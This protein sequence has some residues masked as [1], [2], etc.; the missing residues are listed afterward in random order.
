MNKNKKRTRKG[1]LGRTPCVRHSD[2]RK[3]QKCGKNL[4]GQEK[5]CWIESEKRCAQNKANSDETNNVKGECRTLSNLQ[6]ETNNFGRG[7]HLE[8]NMFCNLAEQNVNSSLM[9]VQE[10]ERALQECLSKGNDCSDDER[11]EL[12]RNL[13]R[14]KRDSQSAGSRNKQR[15]SKKTRNSKRRYNKYLKTRVKKTKKLIKGMRKRK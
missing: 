15:R 6:S 9:S 14:A 13:I 11:H 3:E 5:V 12:Q 8:K 7:G 1:G 4:Y 2:G 10:S